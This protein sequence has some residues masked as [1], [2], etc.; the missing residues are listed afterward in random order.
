MYH[1]PYSTQPERTRSRYV[2]QAQGK[3]PNSRASCGLCMSTQCVIVVV[4]KVKVFDRRIPKS[5]AY[6][7]GWRGSC[8]EL[9]VIRLW[10]RYSAPQSCVGR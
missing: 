1:G 3:A 8:P 10:S 7:A 6:H 2:Q 9:T 4:C 5:G